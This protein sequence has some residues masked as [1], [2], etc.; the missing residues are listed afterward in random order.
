MSKLVFSFNNEIIQPG[1]DDIKSS[2][3]IINISGEENSMNNKI[4]IDEMPPDYDSIVKQS[5]EGIITVILYL[6]SPS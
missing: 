6:M 4:S 3:P 2:V 1:V 5:S